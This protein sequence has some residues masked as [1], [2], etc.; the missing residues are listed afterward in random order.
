MRVEGEG[1]GED[2]GASV[3]VC[4]VVRGGRG[5]GGAEGEW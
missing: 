3:C 4:S 5:G 1:G 2:S